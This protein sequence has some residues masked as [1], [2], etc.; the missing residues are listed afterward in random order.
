M[1]V[2]DVKK[3]YEAVSSQYLEMVNDIKDFEEAVTKE[4]I[5]PERLE[6]I[7]QNIEPIKVNYQRLS[8]IMFLLNL[9]TK[10][11]KKKKYERQNQKLLKMIGKEN[12]QEAVV[13]ENRETLNKLEDSINK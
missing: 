2:K 13:E 12:M 1:S 10:K 6:Q 8:Y 5:E 9:P 11:S 7:K 4:I 3:Y